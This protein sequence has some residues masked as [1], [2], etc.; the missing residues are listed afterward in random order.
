[1]SCWTGD[2][3]VVTSS[4]LLSISAGDVAASP[5]G[6]EVVPVEEKEDMRG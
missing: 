1:M 4:L 3:A 2:V 5:L 6:P